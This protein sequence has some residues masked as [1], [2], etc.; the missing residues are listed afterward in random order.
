MAT[1]S[2]AGTDDAAPGRA[3]RVLA[4]AYFLVF[5]LAL[6]TLG[7]MT[8]FGHASDGDP[9]ARLAMPVRHVSRAAPIKSASLPPP[10]QNAGT[11]GP[12][13][14]GPNAQVPPNAPPPSTVTPGASEPPTSG[15]NLTVDPA[16]I[17]KTAEG[18]LPRIANDGRTPMNAYAPPA[19]TD[20]GF[21]I[22]IVISGLGISAKGTALAIQQLPPAVTLAFAPYESDVAKWVAEARRQGHEVLLEV[23]MEPYDFPDSD[24][25]PH[26]LR[27]GEGEDAN[28]QHMVWALT[29]F[30]GYAGV[31]NNQGGRF[32]ADSEAL[33]PVMTYL[34]RRGLM[35]YDDG[36]TAKSAAPDI[37]KQTDTAF[38]RG[39]L[40][41]D[42]V[43]DATSIDRALSDL[44]TQAR[45][46]GSA[47]GTAFLYPVTVE[48]LAQWSR[49]L[50]ARGF[51]LVPASAIVGKSK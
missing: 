45:A 24:P 38:V 34:T 37:A 27:T 16:L 23:P 32:L 11:P 36:S 39:S 43:Q 51:V 44:E 35:F 47:V 6:C 17:E 31:T 4:F 3:G 49:G 30:T 33:E 8:F 21:R 18:P 5:A 12:I 29:R 41:V 22:A 40:E 15:P 25:G 13:L 48:R 9:V 28:T 46:N 19:T 1:S 14:P 10:I 26:T 42:K 2:Y 50:S 7:A 20:K